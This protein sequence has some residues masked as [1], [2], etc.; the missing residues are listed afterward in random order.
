M[1]VFVAGGTGV[2]GRPLVQALVD[3]GHTVTVS[4]RRRDN[5]RFVEEL[6][7]SPVM[8]HGLDGAEVL[9]VIVDARPQVI[10]NLMTALSGP[11]RD[12]GTWLALTNRLRREGTKALMDAAIAAGS[13][14]VVAQSASFMAQPGGPP[15]ESAPPYLDGPGPIGSHVQANIEAEKMVLDTPEIEGVVLRYGFLYG[16][17]TAIGPGGELA[18]AVKAGE[19]PI[20]GD[21][22]GRYPFVHLHDAASVTVQAVEA[23]SPGVYN[24]VDDEPAPQAEWLPYLAR[25]LQAPPPQRVSEDEAEK[26]IGVQAVYYGNRLPA[27]SNAKAKSGLGFAPAYPSWRDGFREVFG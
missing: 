1:R 27:A 21:G 20:V 19:M 24:I 22:A 11:S 25:I 14:R 17:G 2:I 18:T 10:V 15:D 4:S 26:S 23:G 3:R 9:R 6:G 13:L 7:A 12:Y 8:M 5:F 16:D